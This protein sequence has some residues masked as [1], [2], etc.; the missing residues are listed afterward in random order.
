MSNLAALE[1]QLKE[2]NEFSYDNKILTTDIAALVLEEITD[3]DQ[4]KSTRLNVVTSNLSFTD[5]LF[6]CRFCNGIDI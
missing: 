6:C 3:K 5:V 4:G 2:L 1:R